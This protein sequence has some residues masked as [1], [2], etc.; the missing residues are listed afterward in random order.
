MLFTILLIIHLLCWA[1]YLGGMA[2]DVTTKILFDKWRTPALMAR[3]YQKFQF[4]DVWVTQFQVALLFFSGVAIFFMLDVPFLGNIPLAAGLVLFI[5]SG[6]LFY[7]RLLPVQGRIEKT[8]A[9]AAHLSDADYDWDKHARDDK[10]WLSCANPVV[11]TSFAAFILEVYAAGQ[12]SLIQNAV[13]A[14][15]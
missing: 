4:T 13:T 12:S 9:A 3:M 6:V 15:L 11:L 1:L 5:V 2:S 10:E 8:T 14:T 7:T